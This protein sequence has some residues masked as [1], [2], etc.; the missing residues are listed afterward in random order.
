ML[1]LRILNT[2]GEPW[3]GDAHTHTT[4]HDNCSSSPPPSLA[5]DLSSLLFMQVT[6][7]V[8]L[9]LCYQMTVKKAEYKMYSVA[10]FLTLNKDL[11]LPSNSKTYCFWGRK[12]SD[13][14]GRGSWPCTAHPVKKYFEYQP[15][16]VPWAFDQLRFTK[17]SICTEA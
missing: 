17:T 11:V 2:L 12:S 13:V 3:K 16:L 6:L 14:V 5:G 1:Q 8:L 9:A 10:A 15:I 4:F 7:L